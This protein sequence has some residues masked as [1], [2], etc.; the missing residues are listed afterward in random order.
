MNPSYHIICF[1][2]GKHLTLYTGP[3][4]FG[5]DSCLINFPS[6]IS[7]SSTIKIL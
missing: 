4:P 7:H 1:P 3:D 5:N 2:L 6:L